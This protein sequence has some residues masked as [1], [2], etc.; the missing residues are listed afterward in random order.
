[1]YRWYVGMYNK[2]D[3]VNERVPVFGTKLNLDSS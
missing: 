1:M 2:R 3:V